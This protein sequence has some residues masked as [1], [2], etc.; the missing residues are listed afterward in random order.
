[1]AV[2]REIKTEQE[3]EGDEGADVFSQATAGEDEEGEEEVEDESKVKAALQTGLLGKGIAEEERRM[4]AESKRSIW[5]LHLNEIFIFKFFTCD[6]GWLCK[7]RLERSRSWL[8]RLRRC[9]PNRFSQLAIQPVRSVLMISFPQRFERLQKLLGK[10]KFY[11]DF[12][13]KKMQVVFFCCC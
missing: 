7:K 11:T 8:R 6:I 3:E 13:L 1:M 9:Q 12:L 4:A 2:K 10:S 5:L